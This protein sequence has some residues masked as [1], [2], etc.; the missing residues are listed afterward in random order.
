MNQDRPRSNTNQLRAAVYSRDRPA[1]PGQPRTQAVGRAGS[2]ASPPHSARRRRRRPSSSS[3]SAEPA[4]PG[5][6]CRGR[7]LTGCPQRRVRPGRSR[8]HD[9]GSSSATAVL[10]RHQGLRRQPR[11]RFRPPASPRDAALPALTPPPHGFLLAPLAVRRRCSCVGPPLPPLVLPRVQSF[12]GG[13]LQGRVPAPIPGWRLGSGSSF[14]LSAFF[15]PYLS[16][17]DLVFS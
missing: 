17:A 4:G 3:S 14:R 7:G 5:A 6:A 2:S 10:R 8:R 15:S 9:A 13:E 16:M 12:C 11:F 1:A